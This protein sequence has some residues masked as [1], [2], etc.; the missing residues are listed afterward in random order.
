MEKKNLAQFYRAA[1]GSPVR[2]TF[3][4]KIQAADG[5]SGQRYLKFTGLRVSAGSNFCSLTL[6]GSP[7]ILIIQASSRGFL[8]LYFIMNWPH[9]DDYYFCFGVNLNFDIREIVEI[10]TI[11]SY[12]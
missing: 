5:I 2:V 12:I 3:F 4:V 8:N 9:N 10:N 1:P 6:T 7:M 11:S